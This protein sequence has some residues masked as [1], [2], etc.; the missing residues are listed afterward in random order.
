MKV[1]IIRNRGQR[2]PNLFRRKKI[3]DIIECNGGVGETYIRN[4]CAELVVDEVQED[5]C[6]KKKAS[7]PSCPSP[8]SDGTRIGAASPTL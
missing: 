5:K 6:K 7:K 8:S 3:G 4:R 1:R 2:L